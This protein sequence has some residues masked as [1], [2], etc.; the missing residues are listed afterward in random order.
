M[1]WIIWNNELQCIVKAEVKDGY[2]T[3]VL[4]M[5]KAIRS[6]A[7]IL[8]FKKVKDITPSYVQIEQ[9]NIKSD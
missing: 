2:C 8:A 3:D 7:I 6:R 5:P 4:E 1:I 9:I